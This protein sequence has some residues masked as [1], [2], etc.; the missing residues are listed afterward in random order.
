MPSSV[1]RPVAVDATRSRSASS[2]S[3]AAAGGAA[4]DATIDTGRPA[5]EPGV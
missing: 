5:D 2:S 4:N 1:S 3:R